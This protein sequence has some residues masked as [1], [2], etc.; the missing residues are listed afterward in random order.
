MTTVSHHVG[1]H[2]SNRP[3]SRFRSGLI[4]GACL[5]ASLM[6][7]PTLAQDVDYIAELNAP[8]LRMTAKAKSYEAY[9]Q[10]WSELDLLNADV[11]TDLRDLRYGSS[12]LSAAMQWAGDAPQQEA[13]NILLQRDGTND[14]VTQREVFGLPYGLKDIPMD[15]E[16]DDFSVFINGDRL[17][18]ADFVYGPAIDNLI[19]LLVAEAHRRADSGDGK[20]AIESLLAASRI[21][22]QLCDRAFFPEMQAGMLGLIECLMQFREFMWHYYETLTVEDFTFIAEKLEWLE[23]DQLKPP[24]G[25]EIAGKQIVDLV[26]SKED[27]TADR[28]AFAKTLA[29]FETRNAPLN[30][31]SATAKWKDLMEQHETVKLTR[32]EL[33]AVAGDI[34]LRWRFSFSDPSFTRS[35]YI[36]SLDPVKYAIPRA[37]F[38]RMEELR[39]LRH[40]LIVRQR[41]VITA[42]GV[43]AYQKREGASMVMGERSSNAP[44]SLAEVMPAF[45]MSE[46]MIQDPNNPTFDPQDPD[47]QNLHYLVIANLRERGRETESMNTFSI[48]TKY[49][50]VTLVEGWPLLY[51]IG[52]DKTDDQGAI[53]TIERPALGSNDTPNGDFVFWPPLEVIARDQ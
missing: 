48:Q 29:H 18:E 8:I 44:L 6:A 39:P 1:E 16:V 45:V 33:E 42:A 31:F 4:A 28:E 14:N 10:A 34:R 20:G 30:R 25:H 3:T 22:R 43:A 2:R 17:Y 13:I 50:R 5:G 19:L 23:L 32:A 24:R 51:S 52:W 40:D 12:S 35:P 27:L 26:F 47:S 38:R 53:H 21:S 46:E 11:P 7:T 49:G 37:V 41:G 15:M 36:D 9:F